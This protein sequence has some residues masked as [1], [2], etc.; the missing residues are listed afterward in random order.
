MADFFFFFLNGIAQIFP[1][2]HF[3]GTFFPGGFYSKPLDI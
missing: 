2:T 1:A 3:T